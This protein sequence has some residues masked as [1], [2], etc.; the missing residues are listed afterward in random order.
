[1]HVKATPTEPT[2]I[3]YETHR[4]AEGPPVIRAP[5]LVR[6]VHGYNMVD[7]MRIKQYRVALVEDRRQP[8]GDALPVQV[9]RLTGPSGHRMVW[10][11]SMLRASDFSATTSDTRD[12]PFPRVGTPD[13]PAWAPT[14]LKWSSFRHPVRNFKLFL[15]GKWN[16]SRSDPLTFLRLRQ[17]AWASDVLLTM[18]S[19]YHGSESVT[20][21]TEADV[22]AYVLDAHKMLYRQFRGHGGLEAREATAP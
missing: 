11:T 9:W 10:V 3:A 13:D 8:A 16:A 12:M 14:R 4:P 5:I 17:P 1:V 21:E 18:V 2:V 22:A 6:L 19:E 20:D 7:C 15:C